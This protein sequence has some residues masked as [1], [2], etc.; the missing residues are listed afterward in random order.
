MRSAWLFAVVSL[1]VFAVIPPAAAGPVARP[2]TGKATADVFVGPE[3]DGSCDYTLIGWRTDMLGVGTGAHL[4]AMTFAMTHCTPADSEDGVGIV[5]GG[6]M[7]IVAAN[8]ARLDAGY[9]G[10]TDPWV[11]TDEGILI[12]ATLDITITGGTGRFEE[13]T[14]EMTMTG[15]LFVE[16]LAVQPYPAAM[17]WT[18]SLTY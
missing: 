13:A 9:E 2:F 17:T 6:E 16:D 18:G 10:T 7:T 12:G 5:S 8:G 11:F 14:G 15:T 4:G 1:S 3:A